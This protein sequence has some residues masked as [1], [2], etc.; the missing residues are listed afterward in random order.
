MEI[1][2]RVDSS[3]L[4]GS[5]HV[6]RCLVLAELFR[7]EQHHVTFLC[8]DLPSHC[9]EL[10]KAKNFDYCL[11]PFKS[12]NKAIYTKHQ[13]TDDYAIWL[14]VPQVQDAE[15]T[16][17]YLALNPV[18]LLIVD[19]YGLDYRWQ[20]MIKD[21]TRKL[22]VI[23]DLANRNHVCDVLLDHNYYNNF[24]ERYDGLV[25][26]ECV[27]FLG[28]QYALLHSE[29]IKIR[30]QRAQAR[31][32]ITHS[33]K[34][35][36]VFLGGMDIKNHTDVILQQ[37]LKSKYANCSIDVVL[38]K[39]NTFRESLLA[40]YQHHQ[41]IKF[42]I[43]PSYYYQLM[44]A[45]DLSINAGGVSALERLYIGLPSI[46]ICTAENQRQ[47]CLDFKIGMRAEFNENLTTLSN[48][49]DSFNPKEF[50]FSSP[51]LNH[52][53]LIQLLAQP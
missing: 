18:D 37:L 12:D 39:A 5:G 1:V 23:D 28:P 42:H 10:I 14:G 36:L 46:L 47:I 29:L 34:N 9:C 21:Q 11:L 16:L 19:V 20:T 6:M 51:E 27:K 7:N 32:S 2:I 4:I 52:S 17:Y 13:P 44:E 50:N 49:L 35:I 25:P 41:N 43:Q 22:M 30:E 15:E 38:G 8:R 3:R 40:R 33:I 45:A 26:K 48:T 31:N 53:A 24:S